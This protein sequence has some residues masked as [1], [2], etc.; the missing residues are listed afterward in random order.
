MNDNVIIIEKKANGELVQI[1]ERSWS[2]GM[3][4]M[5][6]NVNYLSVNEKEYEMVEGRLNV[7]SGKM[8]LLVIS[9]QEEAAEK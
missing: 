2:V 6:Q 4:A 1:D 3:I 8:E 5:L 7:N 9:V